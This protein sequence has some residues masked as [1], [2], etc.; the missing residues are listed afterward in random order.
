[1]RSRMLW[2]AALA[3]LAGCRMEGGQPSARRQAQQAD[4][5][6]A[7]A[8]PPLGHRV[9]NRRRE[10]IVPG[11]VRV[12]VSTIVRFDLGQDSA[13]QVLESLLASERMRDSTVAAIR[14]LGY[15]PPA[16]GHGA[17]RVTLVPL[18]YTDWAPGAFDSLSAATRRRPYRT[19]TVFLHDA[20]TLR[21]MGLNPNVGPVPPGS[22][23]RPLPGRPLP[24]GDGRVLPPNH[25]APRRP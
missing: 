11:L 3:V 7:E 21:A 19:E 16:A 2:A 17:A 13:K 1:M 25:P 10:V 4:S 18:A 12:T 23:A 5:A 8:S 22:Q 15:L 14:I 20:E 9:F 6:T 24:P